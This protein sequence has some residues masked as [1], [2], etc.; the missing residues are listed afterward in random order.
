MSGFR[1]TSE[2]V[3]TALEVRDVKNFLKLDDDSDE[4]LV[5]TL[6]KVASTFIENYT[7]RSFINRTIELFIDG[8]F[9]IDYPLHEG[10]RTGPDMYF[11]RR[12]IEL[13]SSPVST[14]SSISTF[15]DDD[16][17]TTF[18][19]SSY[20]V[21]TVTEPSRIVLRNGATWPTAL[22]VSN[23]IKIEYVAGYGATTASIPEPLRLAMYQ[24]IAFLY[25]HRGDFERFPPPEM[26]SSIQSL[27]QPYR[28]LNFSS[29]PYHGRDRM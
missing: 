1:V 24:Y 2:P 26:P 3:R 23:G 8:V 21:D 27:I 14:V 11:R 22:R 29:N 17:E 6:I 25:E 5:R 10:T 13:P 16:V 7:G 18:L 28:I 12:V 9:E 19:A 15:N 20:F 4:I